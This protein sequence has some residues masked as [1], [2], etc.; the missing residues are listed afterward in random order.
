MRTV[1][2]SRIKNLKEAARAYEFEL[3]FFGTIPVAVKPL[4]LDDAQRLAVYLI[5]DAGPV[6]VQIRTMNRLGAAYPLSRLIACSK[7][8]TNRWVITHECAHLT[9]PIGSSVDDHGPE[10]F[11]VY[12]LLVDKAGICTQAQFIE[13]AQRAGIAVATLEQTRRAYDCGG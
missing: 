5:G 2:A 6:H 7:G 1:N 4:T 10:F 3:G 11:Y 13:H 12:S 9:A 8:H